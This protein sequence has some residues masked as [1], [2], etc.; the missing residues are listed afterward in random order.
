M[1]IVNDELQYSVSQ[2][3]S[4]EHLI[5]RERLL[6]NCVDKTRNNCKVSVVYIVKS[7]YCLICFTLRKFNFCKKDI[8][9]MYLIGT[10]F[11]EIHLYS[12]THFV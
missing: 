5:S 1:N 12:S 10:N 2:D 7:I 9:G 6:A 4:F 3:Y 8:T 11:K